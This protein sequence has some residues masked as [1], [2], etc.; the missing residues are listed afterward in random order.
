MDKKKKDIINKR[1]FFRLDDRVQIRVRKLSSRPALLNGMLPIQ[2][3]L[4]EDREY[5]EHYTIDISAMGAKFVSSEPFSEGQFI[6]ITF[7]FKAFVTPVRVNAVILR[8][9]KIEATTSAWQI[10]IKF[11]DPDS[12]DTNMIERYIFERQRQLIAEKRIGF[13]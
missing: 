2:N 13:L 9:D 12:H 8:T 5:S 1:E 10:A 3:G 6:A 4:S 11:I 7:L